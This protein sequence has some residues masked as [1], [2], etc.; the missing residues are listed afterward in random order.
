MKQLY[1]YKSFLNN[2]VNNTEVASPIPVATPVLVPGRCKAAAE[3]SMDAVP[4]AF[5]RAELIGRSWRP[6]IGRPE[7]EGLLC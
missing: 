4:G 6:V 1:N 5:R 7:V 3:V 2:L